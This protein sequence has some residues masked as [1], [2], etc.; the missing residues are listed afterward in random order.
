MKKYFHPISRHDN[1]F[2]VDGWAIQQQLV[3]R[4]ARYLIV[5]QTCSNSLG[6]LEKMSWRKL[7]SIVLRLSGKRWHT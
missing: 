2:V 5:H 3:K 4:Y 7:R 1:A 6:P